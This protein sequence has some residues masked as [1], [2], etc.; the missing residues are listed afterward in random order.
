MGRGESQAYC[1]LFLSD[2]INASEKSIERLKYFAKEPDG[3]KIAEYDL[4][5]RG[6]G[7]VYGTKQSGIPNLKIASLTDTALVSETRKAAKLL[8]D[9]TKH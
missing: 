6:P 8:L 9:I 7:E 4:Q 2:E 3:L 5:S 1:F